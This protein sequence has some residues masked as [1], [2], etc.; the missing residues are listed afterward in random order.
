MCLT[1]TLCKYNLRKGDLFCS[2]FGKVA[3]SEVGK[4]LLRAANV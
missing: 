2:K 3:T 1:S 4:Y